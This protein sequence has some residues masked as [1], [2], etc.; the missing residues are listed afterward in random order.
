MRRKVASRE[1][2]LRDHS[3]HSMGDGHDLSVEVVQF[4]Q[5]L[6]QEVLKTVC[7]NW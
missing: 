4:V 2:S 1:A 5:L 7:A 6:V 3:S